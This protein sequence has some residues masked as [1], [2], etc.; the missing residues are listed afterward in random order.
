MTIQSGMTDLLGLVTAVNETFVAYTS[1]AQTL[2]GEVGVNASQAS[3]L[4]A[5]VQGGLNEA[6]SVIQMVAYAVGALK[7]S[8]L[9][10]DA[11]VQD[12]GMLA[13]LINSTGLIKNVTEFNMVIAVLE[14]YSGQ[15]A[16][17]LDGM[18]LTSATPASLF[19]DA[20]QISNFKIS[21]NYIL[22]L[23]SQIST[24]ATSTHFFF[25]KHC[26]LLMKISEDILLT[27]LNPNLEKIWE[28]VRP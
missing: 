8:K 9:T 25:T 7:G 12:I 24:S 19:T 27:M 21:I 16:L 10:A 14:Q 11:L 15:I 2:L 18:N 23:K 6:S 13:M 22:I 17:M 20:H 5:E 1:L 26:L 4:L 3:V 28:N